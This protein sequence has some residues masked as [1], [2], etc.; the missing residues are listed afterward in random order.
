[1]DF[2]ELT[3]FLNGPSI[4]SFSSVFYP[5]YSAGIRTHDLQYM[6]LLLNH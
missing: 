2:L 4:A 5:V 1:M 6:S 3:V